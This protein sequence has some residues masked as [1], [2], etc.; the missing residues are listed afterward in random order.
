VCVCVCVCVC[1]YCSPFAVWFAACVLSFP[2]AFSNYSFIYFP[3][4]IPW[5]RSSLFLF[6]STAFSG[7]FMVGLEDMNSFSLFV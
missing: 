3:S 7:L 2:L 1:V 4:G 6:L 5:L